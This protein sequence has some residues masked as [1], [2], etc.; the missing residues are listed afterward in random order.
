MNN[1]IWLW[2]SCVFVQL[3]DHPRCGIWYIA[4]AT[5][6]ATI[7]YYL[8]S[9]AYI[10]FPVLTAKAP[11]S[12]KAPQSATSTDVFIQRVCIQNFQLRI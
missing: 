9:H 6:Y 2:G 12:A 11:R 10:V 4:A 1:I 8:H 7:I 5:M 3:I